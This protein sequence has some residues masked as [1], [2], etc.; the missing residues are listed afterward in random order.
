[1]KSWPGERR[2]GNPEDGGWHSCCLPDEIELKGAKL[3]REEP[4]KRGPWGVGR[5]GAQ[6]YGSS[7]ES[8]GDLRANNS[9]LRK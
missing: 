3:A 2:R 4:R 8:V 9:L 1:M 5:D 7:A 6:N